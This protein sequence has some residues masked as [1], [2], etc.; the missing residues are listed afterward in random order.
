M[1]VSI[2]FLQMKGLV[3]C[4]TCTNFRSQ[5]RDLSEVTERKKATDLLELH[6]KQVK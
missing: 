2:N 4:A 1:C 6:L 5:I 3:Y